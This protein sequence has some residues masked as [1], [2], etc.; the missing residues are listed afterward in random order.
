MWIL[1]YNNFYIFIKEKI[2]L[3]FF[4][5]LGITC[6]IECDMRGDPFFSFSSCNTY[7]SPTLFMLADSKFKIYTEKNDERMK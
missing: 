2:P 1:T 7:H 4:F 3:K 6:V 5:L